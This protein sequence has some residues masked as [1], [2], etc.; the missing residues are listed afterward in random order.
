[1]VLFC[2][3]MFTSLKWRWTFLSI[4]SLLL[5]ATCSIVAYNEAMKNAEQAIEEKE[6]EKAIT[7]LETAFKEKRKTK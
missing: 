6:Y 1:M 5:L 7:H 4:Y 3:A 2:L